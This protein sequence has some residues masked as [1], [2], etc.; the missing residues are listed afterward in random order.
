MLKSEKINM[1]FRKK[2]NKNNTYKMEG[3]VTKPTFRIIKKVNY[4]ALDD[5]LNSILKQMNK[6]KVTT[7]NY[8]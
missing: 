8:R 7:K 3:E 2:E 6:R 1:W 5:E 4:N